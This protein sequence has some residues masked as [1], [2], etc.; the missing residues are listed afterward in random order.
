MVYSD[1]QINGTGLSGTDV[2]AEIERTE[3]GYVLVGPIPGEFLRLLHDDPQVG[4]IKM[5]PYCQ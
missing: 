2:V 1:L 3:E 4:T 5:I